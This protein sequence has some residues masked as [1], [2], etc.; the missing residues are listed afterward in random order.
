MSITADHLLLEAEEL[1]DVVLLLSLKTSLVALSEHH[2][3]SVPSARSFYTARIRLFF[4]TFAAG[5]EAEQ[6]R[7]LLRSQDGG[8]AFLT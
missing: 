6:L 4:I 1:L 2:P 3:T 8:A 7:P 5:S